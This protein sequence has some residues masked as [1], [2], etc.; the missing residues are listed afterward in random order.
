MRRFLLLILI[1]L[2]AHFLNAQI[3]KDKSISGSWVLVAQIDDGT[4]KYCSFNESNDEVKIYSLDGK[5]VKSDKFL[6]VQ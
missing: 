1:S 3:T 6:V 4:T 2:S 5:K